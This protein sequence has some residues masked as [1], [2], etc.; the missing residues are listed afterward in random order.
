MKIFFA[1]V[2]GLVGLSVHAQEKKE[3]PAREVRGQID[4]VE[5]II[6]YSAPS[7]KGRSIFGGLVPYGEVWRTGANENTTIEFDKAVKIGET[8]VKPGKYGLFTIP[9]EKTWVWILNMDNANWGAYKYKQNRDVARQTAESQSTSEN[10]EQLLFVVKAEG[11]ELR[12]AKT[13]VFLPISA[14]K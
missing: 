3:S 2:F 8:V 4:G 14:L 10:V 6:K 7:V 1:L 13:S 12:W 11:V 9:G 5:V